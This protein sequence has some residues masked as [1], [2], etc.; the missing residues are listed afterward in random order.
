MQVSAILLNISMIFILLE[1]VSAP[2][3]K[4]KSLSLHDDIKKVA[5]IIIKSAMRT[6]FICVSPLLVY[7]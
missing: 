2:I 4:E 3:E 5:V 6:I 1:A 7:S